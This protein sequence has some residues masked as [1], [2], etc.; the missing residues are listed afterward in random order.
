MFYSCE[1]KLRG[2]VPGPVYGMLTKEAL[3]KATVWVERESVKE[4]RDSRGGLANQALVQFVSNVRQSVAGLNLP[5]GGDFQPADWLAGR[6]E[7]A[8]RFVAALRPNSPST[9]AHL[10]AEPEV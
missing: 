5:G 10:V 2:W 9:C 3:K 6:R 1:C 4:W 8:V 7:A